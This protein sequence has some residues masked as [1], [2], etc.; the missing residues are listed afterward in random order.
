MN[1]TEKIQE[2]IEKLNHYTALYD[3][4]TPDISDEEWDK[5]YF[6]LKELE[7][8]T[9]LIYPNS[10]TQTVFYDVVNS[11]K[12]V[13]HNH[14]MLSLDKTKSIDEVQNFLGN[15]EFIAMAKMDG[16]T[17]SLKYVEGK[18]ISAETRGNGIIGEDITHN[19]LIIPSIPK[20][21]NLKQE[22]IVDGE[23]ICKNDDFEYFKQDYKNPRNFAAGSIRLLSAA[24]CAL[25]KLTFIAWDAIEGIRYNNFSARLQ[26]LGELGFTTVPWV[27]ENVS[28]AIGDIQDVCKQY[29]Y[30]IDGIVFKFEDVAYGKSLGETDHHF[31]NAIAYKFYDEEYETKLLNIEWSMGRTG[32]LTPV[33]IFEPVDDGDSVIERAS[34]HNLN[35]MKE[36][37]GDC[38]HKG[39]KI[40]VCKQ[41]MIIP[42]ISKAEKSNLGHYYEDDLVT[43]NV[44]PICGQPTAINESEQ[45]YCTNPECDG[46]LLNKLEHFFGKK[47]LDVKGVSKATFEKLIDW[48]WINNCVDVFFLFDF[49]NKWIKQPGFGEKSVMNILNS[50]NTVKENTPLDKFICAIGIPL[51][52]S[53]ASKVLAEHFFTWADFRNAVNQKYHF[54]DLYDF[55]YTMEE[56]ILNFN[57]AEADKLAELLNITYK[58]ASP[59]GTKLVNM[60][61]A[62]TGTLTKFKNRA[63]LEQAIAAAGG[64]SVS[65]VTKNTNILVNNNPNSTSAKN[66]AAK[67]LNIPILTEEEFAEKYLD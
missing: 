5:M 21:I 25:R 52:G 29:G 43:P 27:K 45:L 63:A 19:A 46:K 62:I 58:N 39:Q 33:A 60:K 1:E 41:N 37:L 20:Q 38:P 44:C 36:V 16:L 18:L 12:K 51:I 53:V 55:G 8:E 48:G 42:Q 3:A 4:G 67:K 65:S 54:S 66:V 50:L 7:K 28:Y 13:E 22:L 9:G 15:K 17:C 34:L 56:A 26:A 14:K 2:L 24:E 6:E 57:Y 31:K 64:K 10:P 59:V 40:W 49:K 30:P 47:G 32:I 61:I 11:L 35:I 23:I